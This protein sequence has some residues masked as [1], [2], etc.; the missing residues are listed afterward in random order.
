MAVLPW[1]ECLEPTENPRSVP[2]SIPH[3]IFE[4]RA[5]GVLPTPGVHPTSSAHPPGLALRRILLLAGKGGAPSGPGSVKILQRRDDA[6][7][8]VIVNAD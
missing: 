6:A 3:H 4:N 7:G 8:I 5:P 2:V 1:P